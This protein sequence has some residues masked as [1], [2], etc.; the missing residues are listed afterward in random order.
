[1]LRKIFFKRKAKQLQADYGI[2]YR[3]YIWF[4]AM[5]IFRNC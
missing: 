5:A 1:M 3:K 4:N 2:P